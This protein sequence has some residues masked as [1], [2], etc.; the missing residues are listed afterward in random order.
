MEKLFLKHK[1]TIM[2]D[3]DIIE[4]FFNKK[5]AFVRKCHRSPVS[6]MKT[7]WTAKKNFKTLAKYLLARMGLLK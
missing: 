5:G 4:S 7:I 1:E 6:E 2:S 3:K